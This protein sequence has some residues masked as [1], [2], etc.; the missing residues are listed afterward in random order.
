LL[1]TLVLVWIDFV[2][3]H[4]DTQCIWDDLLLWCCSV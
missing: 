1:L 2:V 4:I 3:F